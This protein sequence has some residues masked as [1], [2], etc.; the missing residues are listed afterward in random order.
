[1][2]ASSATLIRLQVP[3]TR[4]VSGLPQARQRGMEVRK[5]IVEGLSEGYTLMQVAMDIGISERAARYHI[6]ILREISGCCNHAG[7]VGWAFRNG[8]LEITQ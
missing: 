7:I 4:H 1:M 2:S 3:G 6:Q 5:R 8:I